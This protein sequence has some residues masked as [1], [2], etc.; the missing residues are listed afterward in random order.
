MKL[1]NDG[2]V[3]TMFSIFAQYMTK[4]P[5]EYDAKLVRS[6]DAK[7]VRSVDIKFAGFFKAAA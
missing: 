2:D 1:K 4:A 6:V 5:I 7:L 3:R